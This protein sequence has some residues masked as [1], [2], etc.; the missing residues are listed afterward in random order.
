M[1]I[2]MKK[3]KN[4]MNT[5]IKQIL[6][7][8]IEKLLEARGLI[9]QAD[10][11]RADSFEVAKA[12]NL[13]SLAII[14]ISEVMASLDDL[15]I[16]P[17]A[18]LIKMRVACAENQERGEKLLEAARITGEDSEIKQK[19]LEMYLYQNGKSSGMR[20]AIDEIFLKVDGKLPDYETEYLPNLSGIFG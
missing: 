5:N 7:D 10:G 8:E 13:V 9:D 19:C 20:E 3:E 17:R 4:N 1:T 6:H 15:V 18:D 12:E 16:V 2:D 14:R 11:C